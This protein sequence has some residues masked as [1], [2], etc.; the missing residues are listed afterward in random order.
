MTCLLSEY[1]ANSVSGA[2]VKKTEI[3]PAITWKDIFRFQLNKVK[4]I[5]NKYYYGP[6]LIMRGI[7][8]CE[9]AARH[10]FL[11]YLTFKIKEPKR[12][13]NLEEEK[14]IPTICEIINEVEEVS[15]DANLVD[16]DCIGNAAS[17]DNL[18]D[19]ELNHIEEGN[20]EGI[21]RK[22][23]INDIVSKTNL[24]DLKNKEKPS[25][26]LEDLMKIII[27]EMYKVKNQVSSNFN[28]DFKIDGKVNK[29]TEP[30][31]IETKLNLVEIEK[32]MKC[33]FIIEENNEANLN[34]QINIENYKNIK[35]FSSKTS[36]IITE[37]GKNIY[38]NKLN[39]VILINEAKNDIN[40]VII[41]LSVLSGAI[42]I[43]GIVSL[44][45][46]IKKYKDINK[47]SESIEIS[48]INNNKN[49]KNKITT[50][51]NL[52]EYPKSSEK[53]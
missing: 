33:K 34:C 3:V 39:E 36:E 51:M 53:L 5:N 7:T 49:A 52:T 19:Y 23:N 26:I 25:F 13:R 45:I 6:S 46:I 20:N 43:G 30:T 44:I 50:K 10:A 41:L 21:L 31:T 16:Y 1:V 8:N 24:E 15:N 38:L 18:D 28:F 32:P 47:K 22:S 35:I 37:D 29:N 9:I 2:C 11:V 48:N 12:N 17:E 40:K 42:F 4:K 27:F 14:K